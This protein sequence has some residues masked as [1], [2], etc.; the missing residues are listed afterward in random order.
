MNPKINHPHPNPP[1]SRG[2][3]VELRCPSLHFV[4]G[5][6]C[7]CEAQ[8]A[9]VI[10]APCMRLLRL[11]PY[12]R[13]L[14]GCRRLAMTLSAFKSTVLP[15]RG[16]GYNKLFWLFCGLLIAVA[17]DLFRPV[18]AG[19]PLANALP[20]YARLFEK[21]YRYRPGCGLCHSRGGGSQPT[22]FGKDF[23]RAGVNLNAFKLIEQKDSDGDKVKNYDEIQAKSNPGDSKSTPNNQGDWLTKVEQEAL[24]TKELSR[25]FHNIE[26]FSSVE[27]MLSEAQISAVEEGLGGNLLDEDKVPTFYFA[28]QPSEGKLKRVGVASFV[29]QPATKGDLIAGVAVN[30]EG[31]VTKVLLIKHEED[32]RLE[33]D[34]FLAQFVGKTSKDPLKVGVDVTLVENQEVASQAVATAVRKFLLITQAAFAKRKT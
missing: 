1:S 4:Q 18:Q 20:A 25:L 5:R 22:D 13:G 2:N 10:S 11:P 8:S 17:A 23:L 26:Q 6:L 32:K 14:G 33:Q 28:V 7:H 12:Q 15:S 16:R 27:G 19:F 24:P 29:T 3:V 21:Q 34:T 9:E 31:K 30:L